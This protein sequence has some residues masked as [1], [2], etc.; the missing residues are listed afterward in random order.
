MDNRER[1]RLS[2]P[3]HLVRVDEEDKEAI[4]N[5][6][7]CLSGYGTAVLLSKGHNE[8]RVKVS[9]FEDP[10]ADKADAVMTILT[11]SYRQPDKKPLR[12]S[13]RPG[14]GAPLALIMGVEIGVIPE[15]WAVVSPVKFRTGRIWPLHYPEPEIA[16]TS[17]LDSLEKDLAVIDVQVKTKRWKTLDHEVLERSLSVYDVSHYTLK[18]L[19]EFES[20]NGLN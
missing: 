16:I 14:S 5:M 11:A 10:T 12:F 9:F 19:L 4:G 18:Q 6:I 13:L 3:E 20:V 1:L 15:G 7:T 2:A 17:L 8:G